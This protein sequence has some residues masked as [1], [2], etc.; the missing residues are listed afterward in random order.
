MFAE[1]HWRQYDDNR[2]RTP[3][4]P[5]RQRLAAASPEQG[6]RMGSRTVNSAQTW[7][8]EGKST[9][10]GPHG[11]AVTN[12]LGE[13]AQDGMMQP[14]EWV[15][16][17]NSGVSLKS[18]TAHNKATKL[19]PA[20]SLQSGVLG[21]PSPVFT[22]LHG[23]IYGS[24]RP[25]TAQ[26][27]VYMWDG[28]YEST[29]RANLA[30][31][32]TLIDSLAALPTEPEAGSRLNRPDSRAALWFRASLPT[33]TPT[34]RRDAVLVRR[35]I[36]QQLTE[37][38]KATLA[39]GGSGGSAL[40]SS[41]D[42]TLLDNVCEAMAMVRD[43][44]GYLLT[45]VL[46]HQEE[47]LT[48]GMSELCGQ[49]GSSCLERGHLMAQLWDLMRYLMKSVLADRDM[50]VEMAVE[51]RRREDEKMDGLRNSNSI[52]TEANAELTAMNEVLNRRLLQRIAE[53]DAQKQTMNE[54]QARLDKMNIYNPERLRQQVTDLRESLQSVEKQLLSSNMKAE[55]LAS[56]LIQKEKEFNVASNKLI[57]AQQE[58]ADALS[59]MHALT[60]RP[61]P[62]PCPPWDLLDEGQSALCV[63]ALRE[64][65]SPEDLHRLLIG[66]SHSGDDLLPWFDK[67]VG[68]CRALDPSHPGLLL[69][70]DSGSGAALDS[71]GSFLSRRAVIPGV[72]SPSKS[73][74]P[75]T[76]VASIWASRTQA[77][78][79]GQV[80]SRM[81]GAVTGAAAGGGA[82]GTS[83]GHK[84]GVPGSLMGPPL[85]SLHEL[86]PFLKG[87]LQARSIATLMAFLP[88]SVVQA[89]SE[90]TNRGV[91][92]DS[93]ACLLLGTLSPEGFEV[94]GFKSLAGALSAKM[95]QG[96]VDVGGPITSA[97][98]DAQ[99]SSYDRVLQLDKGLIMQRRRAGKLS[100]GPFDVIRQEDER[101]LTEARA[102]KRRIQKKV[103]PL[104]AVLSQRHL[105]AFVGLGLGED[106][107]HVLRFEG[108]ITNRNMSRADALRLIKSIWTGYE[109]EVAG[110][111]TN[112]HPQMADFVN[113]FMNKKYGKAVVVADMMYHLLYACAQC[114]MDGDM[115]LFLKVFMYEVD[116]STH[117]DQLNL[118][119]LM[120]DTLGAR[121]RQL[122]SK[123]SCWLPK[124]EV[125]TCIQSLLP[126][127]SDHRLQELYNALDAHEPGEL[128]KYRQLLEDENDDT[129]TGFY[130]MLRNQ[131]LDE[132]LQYHQAIE[133]MLLDMLEKS[134]AD[135]VTT[136][137]IT[138]AVSRAHPL[139]PPESVTEAVIRVFGDMVMEGGK[140]R[141][142]KGKEA[143][144]IQEA[145][146]RLRAGW[147]T[148][149]EVV[150]EAPPVGPKGKKDKKG[151]KSKG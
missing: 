42:G 36:E 64:G 53:L 115:R 1:G 55:R 85:L 69:E 9:L 32:G 98:R 89:V 94:P 41:G 2:S 8:A 38:N 13:S 140:A 21:N 101:R 66:I 81:S 120:L 107:P 146:R 84:R 77:G 122:N 132:R 83:P 136:S 88:E 145:L 37:L 54:M 117:R 76:S 138:F 119:Q 79:A 125:R 11:G 30:N 144:G 95:K 34:E 5:A 71:E 35:W 62:P 49:V 112:Q 46:K 17:T 103:H 92:A 135:V 124:E 59:Q 40:S 104:Q 141:K 106:I 139:V 150:V 70:L 80:P 113:T 51:S 26:T 99:I 96:L 60:P 15:A 137:N 134:G 130:E 22:P 75:A 58:A 97:L 6:R 127:K 73:S 19:S 29:L 56:D 74:G 118:R 27:G 109:L 151:G 10:A 61:R 14:V 147:G 87:M 24:S 126:G 52:L 48:K 108:R 50:A 67:L 43:E 123:V 78:A 133:D 100:A 57:E 47:L 90:M 105:E 102:Q 93:A 68:C 82:S 63:R 148:I 116:A 149:D 111:P 25:S 44:A 65:C 110:K 45:P 143:V 142:G 86:H 39:M 4:M 28:G 114:P 3:H 20:T 7:G 31:K 16:N 72:V 129:A 12:A 91:S 18:W 131:L 128:V 33:A 23:S 121:D